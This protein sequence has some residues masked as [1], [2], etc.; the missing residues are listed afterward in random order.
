[1]SLGL[2]V[3]FLFGFFRV[4]FG[5]PVYTSCV[6]R[7]ALRFHFYKKKKK[8]LNGTFYVFRPASD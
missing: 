3:G 5:S 6:H 1:L 2:F 7:G 4:S 8:K